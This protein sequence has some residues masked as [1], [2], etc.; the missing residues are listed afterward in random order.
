MHFRGES[1]KG[2]VPPIAIVGAALRFPGAADPAAFHELT[3]TGRRIIQHSSAADEAGTGGTTAAWTAT[4]RTLV[5]ETAAAALRDVPTFG[6]PAHPAR[7]GVIIAVEA[8]GPELPDV[9][10]WV[11]GR[12]GLTPPGP[13]HAAASEPARTVPACSLRAIAT[14]CDALNA[15][16]LDLVLAGGVSVDNESA[17]LA[18]PAP[19]EDM[20]VYDMSPTGA[21][22]GEGCG[23]I[24]LMRTADAWGARLPV[25]AE[26]A[27][28]FATD[29][30][31]QQAAAI[32]GAYERAD[33]DPADVQLIEGHGAA[34]AADDLAELTALLEVLPPRPPGSCGRCAIGAVSA[35]IGDTRSAAGVAA[36]LKTALAM[37]AGTIPPTTGCRQPHQLLLAGPTPFRLVA[38]PEPWPETEIRLAAVNSL[39]TAF[40]GG[41]R[42]GPVHLVLRREPDMGRP[43]G[44]RRRAAGQDPAADIRP[45]GTPPPDFPE[46]GIHPRDTPPP[47][48][49]PFGVPPLDI[50]PLGIPA[51]GRAPRTGPN[52]VSR[53]A[54]PETVIAIRGT[55]RGDLAVTLD[56]IAITAACLPGA[57]LRDFARELASAPAGPDLPA[58]AAILASDP[59]QL[60]ERAR[61][62]AAALRA[63]G[64]GA[65]RWTYAG[66]PGVYLSEGTR[67]RVGLLFPGLASTAVE[68]SALLSASMATLAATERLG[69]RPSVA[70]G[71]SFGEITAL[72]WAGVITFGEAA[73]FAAHRAE[74]I[75]ATSGRAAMARVFASPAAVARLCGGTG[76]VVAAQES[77]AQHVLAGSVADIRDLPRRAAV[78]RADV[79]VLS[80]THAL[81]SPAMTPSVPPLRAAANGLRFMAPRRRLVSAV[82]GLD[83]TG[84]EDTAALIAGQLA[85]PALLADALAVAC[86][87]ADLF[88]LTARD[89]ALA[90]AAGAYGRV[91]VVQAPIETWPGSAMAALA[92]LYAAK[93]V[94]D[95]RPFL[96]ADADGGTLRR[97]GEKNQAGELAARA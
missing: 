32:R 58:R 83:L 9:A 74:I 25:Y 19:S 80:V 34:S 51:L 41:I 12:L 26:I 75:S 27:G 92:A 23:V 49:P 7:T 89:P 70:V 93:A 53:N 87:D 38:Q 78:L 13:A 77:P 35:N 28:W 66:G 91:P 55:D 4:A 39:G 82:T 45:P 20:R 65:P 60:A 40:A 42:T 14:A 33:V 2:P 21:L 69:V 96:S 1:N 50:P 76:L 79:D 37:A 36:V 29:E 88:L 46:P 43:P 15:G 71:Y 44:R 85:R 90:R 59:G 57:R 17:F 64:P 86:A 63:A 22:P 31:A 47:G 73:R 48:V 81:H 94:D 6:Q 84:E 61:I 5:A 97:D 24:A 52:P 95:L 16:E 18:G 8:P 72:A 68:H 10:G 30:T 62:A 67:G 11:R 54:P 56:T 3:V